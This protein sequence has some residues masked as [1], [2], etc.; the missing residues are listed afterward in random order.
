ML[1]LQQAAGAPR[2]LVKP[3]LQVPPLR[4]F[5][6]VALSQ[7]AGICF[8]S[9]PPGDG[10]LWRPHSENWP[11]KQKGHRLGEA[12]HECPLGVGRGASDGGQ[13]EQSHFSTGPPCPELLG[14]STM[15]T[16]Q[17]GRW[18]EIMHNGVPA[19]LNAAFFSPGVPPFDQETDA[20]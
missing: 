11:G 1:K 19:P 10:T 4:V 17:P 9:K 7:G 2:R 5:D 13:P 15:D 18:Q 14:S 6:P 8:S 20:P 12:Q 3:R 16:R